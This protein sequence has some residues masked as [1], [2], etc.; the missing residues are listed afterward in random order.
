MNAH[1]L[2]IVSLILASAPLTSIAHTVAG[3]PT[4]ELSLERAVSTALSLSPVL[5]AFALG[6]PAAEAR[7]DQ[8]ALYPNPELGI[9]VENFGG[10]GERDGFDATETTFAFSQPLLLGGKIAGRKG[11]ADADR[12]LATRDLEAVRLDIAALTTIAFNNVIMNQDR[13]RLTEELADLARSFSDTV[14]ARVE[15]GKVSPV[16]EIR[17][18]AAVARAQVDVARARRALAAARV[19]LAETWGSSDP[20]FTRAVGLLPRPSVSPPRGLLDELLLQ[21]PEI[22]RLEEQVRRQEQV[23]ELEKA[24]GVPDLRLTLGPRHYR[25]TGGWAWVG[26]ISVPLPIFNRNQGAR[27][28]AG[29]ELER[30]RH[31]AAARRTALES[32]LS[33]I[34]ERLW[35]AGEEVRS[36]EREI[37][38]ASTEAFE[39][40]S[41]GFREGKFGFLEVLDAQRSL[42]EARLL[43]LDGR[44][45]YAT[46]VVELERLIGRSLVIDHDQSPAQGPQGERS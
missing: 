29:F 36:Y 21:T 42:F 12:A 26:G 40:I 2:I 1:V 28:A 9:E 30:T 11:V 31:E 3:E 14:S 25:D 8:A 34:L 24:R 46:A 10:S 20:R 19:D 44:Q 15:A 17:A 43:L 6:V 37:V 39:A 16:E 27:R 38:P 13:V 18:R 32:R 7:L 33:R 35:A 41:L 22:A 23:V 5:A 4:G 45:R